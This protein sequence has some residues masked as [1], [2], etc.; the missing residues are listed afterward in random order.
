[1]AIYNLYDQ[2][3]QNGC[4]SPKVYAYYFTEWNGYVMK[5]LHAHPWMEIMYVVHGTCE[6]A[7]DQKSISMKNGEFIFI[8]SEVPHK[9][10][11]EESE[12]CRM[13][14]LEFGFE[15]TNDPIFS[16]EKLIN[17][18]ESIGPMIEAAQPYLLIKDFEEVYPILKSLITEL[19]SGYE[20]NEYLIQLFL[21]QLIILI[22]RLVAT[23]EK[24]LPYRDH[25]VRKALNFMNLKYD[26]PILVED[27][28]KEV[29]VHPT[30]LHRI[31]KKYT[32]FTICE[33]LTNIRIEKAKM[34]LERTD[35]PVIDISGYVGISS[36][37][38]FSYIFKNHTGSSPLQFRRSVSKTSW[39]QV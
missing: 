32:G 20:G 23:N 6:I 13:L 17:K 22:S 11:L 4:F 7:F 15:K 26:C 14:N 35:I 9:L 21:S 39:N 25:Y 38:Y 31:F 12:S 18:N 33:Y 5:T 34:L 37:Q 1:M 27:I 8:S 30:Y 2:E 3:I 16:M 10:V 24:L 29:N 36:R 28:A 19:T